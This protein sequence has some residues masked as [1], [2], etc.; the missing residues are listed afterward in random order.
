[1]FGWRVSG[2]G[3]FVLKFAPAPEEYIHSAFFV[4][5]FSFVGNWICIC[6]CSDTEANEKENPRRGHGSKRGM[7]A[8]G[9]MGG[10]SSSS[11]GCQK[12]GL[13]TLKPRKT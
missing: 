8:G 6:V 9:I 5:C 7:L 2:F 10:R 1:M 11:R 13:K 3:R 4:L 12:D